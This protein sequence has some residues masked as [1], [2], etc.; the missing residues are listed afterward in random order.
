SGNTRV[1]NPNGRAKLEGKERVL[2]LDAASGK[3]LWK[4]EYDVTY[5]ISYP[6]G[7][8]CTPAV[9]GGKVYALGAEGNLLCLDAAKGDL[10]WGKDLKKEYGLNEAPLWGFCSHPLIDG[11]RLYCIVG[12]K[13][14]VV[15]AFDKDTGKELWTSLSS[16]EGGGY[17]SPVL[18]EA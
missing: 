12:G 2:C 14:K 6:A 17:G 5:A 16:K 8:R 11:N 15:A 9:A 18:I 10:V 1:D 3:E 7:P 4:Y 13:D